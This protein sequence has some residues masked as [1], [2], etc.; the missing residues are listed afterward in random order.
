MS[1]GAIFGELFFC[2]A[3]SNSFSSSFS[4]LMISFISKAKSGNN[5]QNCLSS[6]L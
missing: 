1:V 5:S 3:S 6:M 4:F 2:E